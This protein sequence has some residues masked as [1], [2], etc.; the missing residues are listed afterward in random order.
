MPFLMYWVLEGC[1]L[2]K[3]CSLECLGAAASDH[4]H[5]VRVGFR[6]SSDEPTET[7]Q[8]SGSPYEL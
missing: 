8:L 2:G 5:D 1:Q 3:K 4:E 6:L 7:L